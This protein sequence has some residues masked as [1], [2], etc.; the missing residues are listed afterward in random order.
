[1]L[2]KIHGKLIR[3]LLDTGSGTTL[4]RSNLAHK[5][6]L[7]IRPV[8]EG[9]LSCLFAAEGS[10]LI[11][12]GVADVT[13]NISGL[14]VD[15]T[16]YVVANIAESLILGSDFLSHNHVIIDYSSKIVSLCADLVRTPIVRNGDGQ[17][18]ARLTK[19][20]CIPPGN[21]RIVSIKC[22]PRFSNSDVLVEAMPCSQFSQFA[23]ARSICR[24]DK[25]SQTVARM[26]NCLPHTLVLPKGTKVATVQNINVSASCEPFKVPSP[27]NEADLLESEQKLT[28]QELNQFATDHGF[29]INPDLTESQRFELLSLLH[30]YKA[31]FAR[32]LKE[33]RRYKN[34]ELELILK[35]KRPSFRR[36]YKLSQ[37]DALECHRQINEMSECGIIEPS[38]N[39]MYQSAIFTVRKAS[40]QKR[41]VLDLRSINDKLEPFLLQLPDMQQLLN[42]LAGQKGQYYSSLDLACGFWQIPLKDGISRDVTSFCDPVTGLRYRYTCAPFGLSTSPAAMITVLMGIM[43]PLV[44]QNIA[45][46]YMDD[47]S[48]ASSDWSQHLERLD[49]VLK[50]LDLNNLSCQPTK[51]S[52]AFPSI[53]FLGYEVSKDGLKITDDKIKLMKALKPPHDKKSLQKVFGIWNFFK[54]FCSQFS[55]STYHMRQLLKK[56]AKFEWTVQCQSEFDDIIQKLTHAPILQPLSVNKDFYVYTDSSYFGT[57]F[58]AFQPCDDQ[59]DRLHVIGYGGQALTP[60]HRAWSVLQIELLAVYHA[61]KAYEHYCRHRT[62]NIFSDNISLVY[63]KGMAMGSPREKR[64]ATYLMGF[65]LNFRHVSGKRENLLADSLSRSFEDMNASE[66]EQWIPNVDP[67]DDYLF[68]VSNKSPVAD[69]NLATSSD[70]SRHPATVVWLIVTSHP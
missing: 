12:D 14:F 30:K 58:A 3:G 13:F 41:A 50:T 24:T 40:G 54:N 8:Q 5:L 22:A 60:A 27:R 42:A 62:V 53:K 64:M 25:Q 31:C 17:Q 63:L 6:N 26:L 34:Y 20:L 68:A 66:L 10:K 15:H 45:F 35:D 47:I 29:K 11:V 43:S 48:I 16:V 59:P 28:P 2:L 39:S 21:E 57:A 33:M 49:M 38:Q 4:I 44:S 61:L 56:D 23:V 69:R 7:S 67:K 51:T 37:D 9:Q 65:R 55:Q 32:N 52:L 19:S 1:L 18:V 70:C 36:Q 46:V